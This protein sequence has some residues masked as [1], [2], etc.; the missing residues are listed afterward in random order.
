VL[1]PVVSKERITPHAEG[2]QSVI[3]HLLVNAVAG[4]Y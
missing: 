1:V 4:G 3:W 2:W